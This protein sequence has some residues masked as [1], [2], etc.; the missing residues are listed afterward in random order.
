MLDTIR[1]D[2]WNM[3]NMQHITLNSKRWDYSDFPGG[4]TEKIKGPA[5]MV[6]GDHHLRRPPQATSYSAWTDHYKWQFH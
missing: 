4:G 1:D 5:P 2:T 3:L 6:E